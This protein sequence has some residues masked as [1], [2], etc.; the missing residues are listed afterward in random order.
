M[1]DAQQEILLAHGG[2]PTRISPATMK[3]Q[4]SIVPLQTRT[5]LVVPKPT[6]TDIIEAMA[7]ELI[8]LREAENK[9]R[10][11]QRETIQAKLDK[12]IEKLKKTRVTL[13]NLKGNWETAGSYLWLSGQNIE[14]PKAMVELHQQLKALTPLTTDLPSIIEAIKIKMKSETILSI[15]EQ[16]GV[17]EGMKSAFAKLGL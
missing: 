6:K 1:H 15:L 2:H 11:I 14:T 17:R 5:S 9:K 8:T 7:Q 16:P 10:A 3:T 4:T 13:G 12:E